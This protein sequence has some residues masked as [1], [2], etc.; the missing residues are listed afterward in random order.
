MLFKRIYVC[1]PVELM[2]AAS[3]LPVWFPYKTDEC[4]LLE[5]LAAQVPGTDRVSLKVRIL[6]QAARWDM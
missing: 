2:P 6:T 5:A 4:K 3:P 1:I